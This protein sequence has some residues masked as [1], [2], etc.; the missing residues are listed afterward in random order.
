M[1]GWV[2]NVEL[3]RRTGGDSKIITDG[4]KDL[5]GRAGKG[6]MCSREEHKWVSNEREAAAGQGIRGEVVGWYL[7]VGV[8][9]E[10]SL[11]RA[12]VRVVHGADEGV[13]VGRIA[14]AYTG[15]GDRCGSAGL[16][17]HSV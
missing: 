8:V 2:F 5:G 1:A 6:G 12:G 15:S 4:Q 17:S 10:N 11:T 9:K 13:A 16:K 7:P 3:Q 14:G